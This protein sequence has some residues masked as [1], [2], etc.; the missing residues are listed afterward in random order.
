VPPS[1]AGYASAVGTEGGTVAPATQAAL[2]QFLS[3]IDSIIPQIRHL[4]VPATD[5]LAGFNVALINEIGNKEMEHS[6]LVDA[7][8]SLAGG[9]QFPGSSNALLKPGFSEEDVGISDL[10]LGAYVMTHGATSTQVWLGS[11]G[12]NDY[13]IGQ[14][15]GTDVQ[16]TFTTNVGGTATNFGQPGLWMATQTT[17]Y[18][19]GK[20]FHN[21]TQVASWN[22]FNYA[23][24]GRATHSWIYGG[25]ARSD[26]TAAYP[27]NGTYGLMFVGHRFAETT[28]DDVV[29]F[30]NAVNTLMVALGRRA[31]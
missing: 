4:W 27:S 7:D 15:N 24:S 9:I 31:A 28:T 29:V 25:K 30:N 3:D 17:N 11:D 8:Y 16:A 12:S 20:I 13:T 14:V 26:G 18:K 6:G 5:A 23:Q 19:N 1:A 21:G 2:D 22:G 10:S